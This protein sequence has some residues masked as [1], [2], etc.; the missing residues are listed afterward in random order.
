[1][2][3]T[4]AAPA[5]PLALIVDDDVEVNRFIEEGLGEPYRNGETFPAEAAISKFEVGGQRLLTV[6]LRDITERKRSEWQQRLLAELGAVLAS[7]LNLEKTIA[8]IGQQG[9]LRYRATCIDEAGRRDEVLR[10][11]PNVIVTRPTRVSDPST[12]AAALSGV[13]ARDA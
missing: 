3:I 13:V 5:S 7:S 6:A 8:S 4:S 9:R 2:T 1:M 11:L 12:R 10:V